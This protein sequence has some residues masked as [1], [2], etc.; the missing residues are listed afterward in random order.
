M[1]SE[2]WCAPVCFV[3][4]GIQL[5]NSSCLIIVPAVWTWRCRYILSVTYC[6]SS[7]WQLDVH[8]SAKSYSLKQTSC[9]FRPFLSIPQ[10]NFVVSLELH[11]NNSM[12]QRCYV[13]SQGD[14]ESKRLMISSNGIWLLSGC[15]KDSE[16]SCWRWNF[17]NTVDDTLCSCSRVVFVV[18]QQRWADQLVTNW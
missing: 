4:F 11:S 14:N 8:F 18:N 1:A 7:S 6:W 5:A 13:R 9:H 3:Q 15:S 16:Q 12:L 2:S 17:W 10:P